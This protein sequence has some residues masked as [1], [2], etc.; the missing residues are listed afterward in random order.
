MIVALSTDTAFSLLELCLLSLS[1]VMG[2]YYSQPKDARRAILKRGRTMAR[3]MLKFQ[4]KRIETFADQNHYSYYVAGVIGYLFNDLLCHNGVITKAQK[5]NLHRYAHQ[6]GLALQ[7]VNILRDIAKDISENRR[8][9]P[10]SLL[11]KYGL[12]YENL[13]LEENREKA[14]CILQAQIRNARRYLESA[15]KYIMLLPKNALRV[16]MFCI[17]PLFM[18]IESYAKCAQ[19][20]G[21]FDSGTSVKITRMQVQEIVAKSGLWGASNDRLLEWFSSSMAARGAQNANPSAF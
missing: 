1:S 15:I 4:M 9:W 11:K 3:G 6:F 20:P 5:A 12:S 21:I 16:R 2:V 13:C 14:I 18:A 17:I 19:S 7:K 8:Y 10:S